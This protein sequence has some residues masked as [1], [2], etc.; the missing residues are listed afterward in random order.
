MASTRGELDLSPTLIGHR[1]SSP[2]PRVLP[3]PR[4]TD[5]VEE[6]DSQR[7]RRQRNNR[8]MRV[9]HAVNVF[10]PWFAIAVAT[11]AAW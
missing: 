2:F 8:P 10:T 7:R 4:E 3:P 6:G 5:G 11:P 9:E 1:N